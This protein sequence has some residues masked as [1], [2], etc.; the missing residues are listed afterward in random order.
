MCVAS[1]VGDTY[2]RRFNEDPWKDLI[3]R[4]ENNQTITRA[5][6][7][8]LKKEVQEM[9]RLLKNAIEIDKKTGQPDCQHD[10]KMSLL[11]RIAEA[12]GVNL[13]EVINGNVS[14]G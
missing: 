3:G 14:H 8:A 4:K 1:M 9:G 2:G 12:V 5:E 13:D 10:D 7:D 11:R 6:F